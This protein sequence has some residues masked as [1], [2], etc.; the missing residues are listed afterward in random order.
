MKALW[1]PQLLSHVLTGCFAA[2]FLTCAILAA[3]DSLLLLLKLLVFSL[4]PFLLVTLIRNLIS[5]KRPEN[6]KKGSPSFPSRHAYSAFYVATLLF[7]FSG[8][9]SYILLLLAIL[10]ATLRV[11]LGKHY[12][13]DVVAGAFLGVIAAIIALIS[14]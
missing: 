2:A 8:I 3:V 4:I 11:L 5:A 7:R 9:A 10:L 13:R 1:K 12:P 6:A 14:L